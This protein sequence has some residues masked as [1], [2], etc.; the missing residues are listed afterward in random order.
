MKILEAQSA[1][2]TNYEVYTH[3][4]ELKADLDKRDAKQKGET[5]PL[6]AHHMSQA[7]RSDKSD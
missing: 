5:Q 2:L 6:P 4:R 3:L 1:T 7:R